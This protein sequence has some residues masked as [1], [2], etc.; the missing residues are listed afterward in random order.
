MCRIE[1]VTLGVENRDFENIVLMMNQD[2][3]MNQDVYEEEI[4]QDDVVNNNN[5]VHLPR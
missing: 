2:N 4:D 3:E 5:D 1:S